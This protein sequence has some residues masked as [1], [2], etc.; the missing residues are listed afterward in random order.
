GTFRYRYFSRLNFY[1]LVACHHPAFSKIYSTIK[2]QKRYSDQWL[3]DLPLPV[4]RL[5]QTAGTNV[6]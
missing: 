5:L 1:H 3:P 2:V 6:E 4:S